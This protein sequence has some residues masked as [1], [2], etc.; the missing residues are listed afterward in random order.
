MFQVR[1]TSTA[2]LLQV[3]KPCPESDGSEP[4][5]PRYGAGGLTP[6]GCGAVAESE[7]ELCRGFVAPEPRSHILQRTSGWISCNGFHSRKRIFPF[8]W[9]KMQPSVWVVEFRWWHNTEWSH[10]IKK[11]SQ[12]LRSVGKSV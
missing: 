3:K 1:V 6:T 4:Q 2:L 5:N 10:S 12:L 11:Q 8:S 7:A 9:S